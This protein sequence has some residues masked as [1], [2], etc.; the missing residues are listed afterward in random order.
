VPFIRQHHAQIT[1]LHIK[2]MKRGVPDSYVPWGTG[3]API[4]EV[5]QLLKKEPRWRIHS[6]VEYEY[7]GQGSPIEETKKCFE[8]V[9]RALA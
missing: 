3:D 1:N 6:H 2:D 8:F 9:K 4:T 7:K 5:L